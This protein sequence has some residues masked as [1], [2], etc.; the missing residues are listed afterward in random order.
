MTWTDPGLPVWAVVVLML[1]SMNGTALLVSLAIDRWGLPKGWSIQGSPRKPGMLRRHLPLIL[2]NLAVMIVGAGIGF[3]L[4]A[5]GFVFERP[6]PWMGAATFFGLVLF[7]D[8][9][10][11]WIHRTLHTNRDLYRRFHRQHHQAYAPVPIE[12][13]H[14][15]PVEWISGTTLPVAFIIGTILWNGQMNAWV[16]VA[17]AV[18]RQL[19]EMDIH[20]G[21]HSFFARFL[22]LYGTV[23]QHDLHHARPHSGNYAST[24]AIW[25]WVFNTRIPSTEA[26]RSRAS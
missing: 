5:D 11:Y 13:I 21:T 19:H 6:D 2:G 24:L 26:A 25:D 12:Y 10:F 15:H 1:V 3:H 16:L 8:F 14:A 20:S 9:G 17:W 22:P 4:F 7:D 18:F 23:Q